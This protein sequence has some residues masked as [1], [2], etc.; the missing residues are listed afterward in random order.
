MGNC[1]FFSIKDLEFLH[2]WLIYNISQLSIQ[3]LKSISFPNSAQSCCIVF[4]QKSTVAIAEK[5]HSRAVSYLDSIASLLGSQ[6]P[7][8]KLLFFS[9]P[10]HVLWTTHTGWRKTDR[11]VVAGITTWSR[12]F[13]FKVM[14]KEHMTICIQEF[15]LLHF[16]LLYDF[17]R[18][19]SEM[20]SI[21]LYFFIYFIIYC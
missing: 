12:F 21:F 1:L 5:T 4:Q 17:A 20:K 19:I 8:S 3:V 15:V 2:D 14:V 13:F 16:A 6:K 10:T 7:F 9:L 18:C 11:P